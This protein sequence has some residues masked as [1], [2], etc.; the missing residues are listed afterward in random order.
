MPCVDRVGCLVRQHRDGAHHRESR[1]IVEPR[2]RDARGLDRANRGR[3]RL[4]RC[5]RR[6]ARAPGASTTRSPSARSNSTRSRVAVATTRAVAVRPSVSASVAP[7]TSS[8]PSGN[9]GQRGGSIDGH[10]RRRTS[11]RRAAR[12]GPGSPLHRDTRGLRLVATRVCATGFLHRA[13]NRRSRAPDLRP[14][15]PAAT[16]SCWSTDGV[17]RG[18]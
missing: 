14:R 7:P 17:Y 11:A 15:K 10:A 13:R 2:Y 12:A 16:S 5:I 3:P 9:A 8:A 18:S 6:R 1:D 4:R